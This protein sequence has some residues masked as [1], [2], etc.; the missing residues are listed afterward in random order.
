MTS[1]FRGGAR[2][3][4][5]RLNTPDA[6]G[7][8]LAIPVL[9]LLG[10]IVRKAWLDLDV[11]WDSLA[12]HLPFAGLRAGML[13]ASEYRLSQLMTERYN[14]FPIL[15]YLI[16]GG[17]WRATSHIQAANLIGL[18][19]LLPLVGILKKVFRTPLTY[20]LVALLSIPVVLIQ[21]TSSYIDLF[22]NCWMASMLL[23]ILAAILHPESFS[24][25]KVVGVFVCFAVV[26]NS[27][28]QLEPVALAALGVFLVLL[29]VTRRRYPRLK[30]F[31]RNSGTWRKLGLAG[32]LAVLLAIGFVNPA[33]NWIE[34]R[35]PI[36]PLPIVGGRVIAP[37]ELA[38][39]PDYLARS[40]QGFRWLL[41]TVEYKSF[42]GRRPLWT[43]GQGDVAMDSPALF[44]G[45]NFGALVLFNILWLGFLQSK[46][47][48][49]L[50]WA[51]CWFMGLITLVTAFMPASPQSRYYLYWIVCLVLLNLVLIVN[52][53]SGERGR[54][55]RILYVGG[56][57]SFLLFVLCATDFVY[58]HR[59]GTTMKGMAQKVEN[60]LVD[61]RLREGETVCMANTNPFA[62]I[63]A[64]EFHPELR[65][66]FHYK[67]QERYEPA[68]CEGLRPL[69]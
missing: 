34:F 15:P 40:S 19:G 13:S 68:D 37:G 47:R 49:S 21:S 2:K 64:P 55:A 67:I 63:F 46:L 62:L 41:S 24:I 20:S 57:A 60:R 30:F 36:Y 50:G 7:R 18:A 23:L 1:E 33:K 44:M 54:D 22:S 38:A 16:Q 32:A 35:N 6:G 56:M 3:L 43:N 9:L 5:M 42:E 28:M 51:P 27:K 69:P 58:I 10:A 12:Y 8:I 14:G 25:A 39:K 45:G 29:W 17:L 48:S 61:A 4:L 66:R 65:A 11:A 31:I 26:F 59:S 53:L 52:G